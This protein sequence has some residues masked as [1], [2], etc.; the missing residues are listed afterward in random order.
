MYKY[1]PGPYKKIYVLWWGGVGYK[2]KMWVM[3]LKVALYPGS[4]SGRRMFPFLP[5]W[6]RYLYVLRGVK[7]V[8]ITSERYFT[9]CMC[10]NVIISLKTR[11]GGNCLPQPVPPLVLTAMQ[12]F[13]KLK[14][15]VQ[16][17]LQQ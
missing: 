4:G 11:G 7:T 13:V 15:H 14:L 17:K 9:A 8:P 1:K 6:R 10:I 3:L 2:I 12:V 16:S 5:R